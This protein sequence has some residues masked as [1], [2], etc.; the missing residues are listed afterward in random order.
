MAKYFHK[1]MKDINLQIHEPYKIKAG[2][3]QRPHI[4]VKIFQNKREERNLNIAWKKDIVPSKD[5][6]QK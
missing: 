6:L 2:I 5:Q 1:W 3:V 4:M